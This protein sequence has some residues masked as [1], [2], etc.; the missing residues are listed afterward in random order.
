MGDLQ[1][2][3]RK[4]R[5]QAKAAAM[6]RRSAVQEHARL[7]LGDILA[8]LEDRDAEF[9]FEVLRALIRAAGAQLVRRAGQARAVGVFVGAL[10][11][12]APAW[13]SEQQATRE[14]ADALFSAERG[15]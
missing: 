9:V 3:I 8:R 4:R 12:V 14:A 2:E 1:L 7:G 11:N 5:G 10:T 15:Q 6:L 13:K